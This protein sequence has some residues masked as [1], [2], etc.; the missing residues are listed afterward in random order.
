MTISGL[1]E[2]PTYSN[3]RR[4]VVAAADVAIQQVQVVDKAGQVRSI[5]LWRCGPDVLYADN[6]DGLFDSARRKKAPSWLTEQLTSLSQERQFYSD[7]TSKSDEVSAPSH[8]PTDADAP[9]FVQ[10]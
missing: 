6:L 7:G 4:K 8:I 2:T 1:P 5:V 3:Q 9:D 10:G